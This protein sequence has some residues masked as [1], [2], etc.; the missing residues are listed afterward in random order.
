M[1]NT[2][3]KPGVCCL[4]GWQAPIAACRY[5]MILEALLR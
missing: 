1:T 2:R 3:R 4:L 5:R